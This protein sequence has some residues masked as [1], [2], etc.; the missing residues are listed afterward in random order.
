MADEP[1]YSSD[2]QKLALVERNLYLQS[3]RIAEIVLDSV[4]A[5]SE[6]SPRSISL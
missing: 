1:L 5:G 6:D 3:N 4:A 2:E